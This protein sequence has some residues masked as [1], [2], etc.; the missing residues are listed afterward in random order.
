MTKAELIA[1]VHEQAGDA[2]S[3]KTVV[4]VIDAIFGTI[5][6]SLEEDGRFA[7]PGVGTFNVKAR[8][9]RTGRNP[10]TGEPLDI[11]ASNSVSFKVSAKLKA[12]L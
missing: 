3:R 6:K 10:Q 9:A 5:S 2:L 7:V 11:P 8:K 1:R 12:Q 4:D